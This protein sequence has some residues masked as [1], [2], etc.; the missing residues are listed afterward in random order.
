MEKLSRIIPNILLALSL[1]LLGYTIFSS[2][3]DS[4]VF[5]LGYKPVRILSGSMEPSIQT[6]AVVLIKKVAFSNIKVGDI[7][8]YEFNN[9]LV[10]HRVVDISGEKIQTKGDNNNSNDPYT[11]SPSKIYGKAV[12]IANWT[13]PVFRFLQTKTFLLISL[14]AVAAAGFAKNK[15]S[16]QTSS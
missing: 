11:L 12:Y 10:I 13:N 5:I 8:L 16:T 2:G 7:V 4:P 1:L 6:N 9:S 14:I 3:S 15:K